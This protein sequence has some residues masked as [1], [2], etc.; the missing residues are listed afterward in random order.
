MLRIVCAVACPVW[1]SSPLRLEKFLFGEAKRYW[2]SCF[3]CE[4]YFKKLCNRSLTRC[5]EEKSAEVAENSR[6]SNGNKKFDSFQFCAILRDKFAV[7]WGWNCFK[8]WRLCFARKIKYFQSEIGSE[9]RENSIRIHPSREKPINHRPISF[10]SIFSPLCRA[11]CRTSPNWRLRK[12]RKN[13]FLEQ[14]EGVEKKMLNAIV[15]EMHFG[16]RFFLL[17][18]T[19]VWLSQ[20]ADRFGCHKAVYL[21][22]SLTN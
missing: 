8:L 7:K 9:R 21:L 16:L 4:I 22:P 14:K 2:I 19:H 18:R 5:V 10:T 12:E 20:S 13:L 17:A 3:Y 6:K 15:I 1:W 11:H